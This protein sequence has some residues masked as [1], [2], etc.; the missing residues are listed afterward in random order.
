VEGPGEPHCLP[1]SAWPIACVVDRAVCVPCCCVVACCALCS[2]MEVGVSLCA[3]R[4]AAT[5]HQCPSFAFTTR[6][7]AEEEGEG[8]G[9]EP[10]CER[11]RG[12]NAFDT[13]P[14][15]THSHR[16]T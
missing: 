2:S 14:P 5:R 15:D 7:E 6:E 1:S 11:Q 4:Q 13:S 12:S 3:H 9:S 10:R 16:E 8:E